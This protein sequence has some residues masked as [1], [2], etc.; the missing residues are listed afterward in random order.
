ESPFSPAARE[1]G[2][3]S[4]RT[5]S[6]TGGVTPPVS[7]QLKFDFEA[8]TIE[9]LDWLCERVSALD[10]LVRSGFESLRSSLGGKRARARASNDVTAE[11]ARQ[12]VAWLN[13]LPWKDREAFLNECAPEFGHLASGA[14]VMSA[15]NK[16][17]EKAV[18]IAKRRIAKLRERK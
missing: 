12:I 7:K 10:S 1:G 4:E 16:D 14:S 3:G 18:A 17:S 8:R 15:L 11:H 2:T 6:Q 13:A 9:R 5:G